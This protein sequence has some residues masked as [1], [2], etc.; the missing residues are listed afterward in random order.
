MIFSSFFK[1]YSLISFDNI[2]L[3]LKCL[4]F[5]FLKNGYKQ[6]TIYM[7]FQT[8]ESYVTMCNKKQKNYHYQ[9]QDCFMLSSIF[10]VFVMIYSMLMDFFTAQILILCIICTW[11]FTINYNTMPCISN[12]DTILLLILDLQLNFQSCILI[13]IIFSFISVTKHRK[14]RKIQNRF[15]C[16]T[17]WNRAST[18]SFS[19]IF[20]KPFMF[21]QSSLR[22][23]IITYDFII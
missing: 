2:S 10:Y 11:T 3:F 15:I 17:T 16:Y 21:H 14:I 7:L 13:M 9:L 22:D 19:N 18:K 8:D 23:S 20:K 12:F 6:F 1:E 4:F 5:K